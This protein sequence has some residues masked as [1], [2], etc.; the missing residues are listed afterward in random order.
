VSDGAIV[1]DSALVKSALPSGYNLPEASANVVERYLSASL[2]NEAM[3]PVSI[4]HPGSLPAVTTTKRK[5]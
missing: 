3:Y 5:P 2:P 1:V 4:P